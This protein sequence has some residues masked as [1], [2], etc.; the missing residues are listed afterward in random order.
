[1][2]EF[3]IFNTQEEYD[4]WVT[5]YDEHLEK[6]VQSFQKQEKRYCLE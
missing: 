5:K 4:E 3:P 6:Y 1:M 2:N